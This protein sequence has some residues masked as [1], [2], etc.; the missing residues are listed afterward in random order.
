MH[1]PCRFLVSLLVCSSSAWTNLPEKEAIQRFESRLKKAHIY[2]GPEFAGNC[3]QWESAPLGEDSL[4]MTPLSDRCPVGRILDRWTVPLD[5]SDPLFIPWDVPEQPVPISKL[6]A[7]SPRKSKG[8]SSRT[9]HSKSGNGGSG[10]DP[11]AFD[12]LQAGGGGDRWPTTDPSDKDRRIG[13]PSIAFEQERFASK[14][15]TALPVPSFATSHVKIVR[16]DSSGLFIAGRICAPVVLNSENGREDFPDS[17]WAGTTLSPVIEAFCDNR[18]DSNAVA[19]LQ[20]QA[21]APFFLIKPILGSL[22]TAASRHVFLG[23]AAKP[24][25]VEL[26][27]G[28]HITGSL[29]DETATVLHSGDAQGK[30]LFLWCAKDSV[31]LY[32]DAMG[33]NPRLEFT[34]T[35]P[36]DTLIPE[37]LDSLRKF[38]RETRTR[39][40]TD[41]L[42][43]AAAPETRFGNLVSLLEASNDKAALPDD[44]TALHFSLWGFL[45]SGH[46]FQL[47]EGCEERWHRVTK[48]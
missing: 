33:K 29:Y 6:A 4:R 25:V 44:G 5:G 14:G 7:G 23:T 12:I 17:V 16:A 27:Q 30:S 26:F 13:L 28:I 36:G 40:S 32:S 46:R 10:N 34:A 20:S 1:V 2:Q 41:W 31:R 3:L 38:L 18:S 48:D 37:T 19:F 24:I 47:P 15:S 22:A 43:I 9:G 8:A 45:A 35:L 21:N 42:G 11:G 39:T